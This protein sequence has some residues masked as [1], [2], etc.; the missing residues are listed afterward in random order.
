MVHAIRE[1]FEKH[2]KNPRREQ[3]VFAY[4]PLHIAT[5]A[6]LVEMMRMDGEVTAEE[7]YRVAQVLETKFGLPPE[8][9][10]E[11]LQLAEEQAEGATDYYQFT[12]LIKNHLDA[13]EK[14]RLIEY[15]WIVAYA[16]GE[17]H[18]YEEHLVRKIADLLYVS[19]DSF[20]AAKLRARKAQ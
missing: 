16:D 17:L 10:A 18:R 3:H 6:L 2:I 15:L 12:A 5:A 1:F 14:E 7:R 8:R 20:I 4:D 13:E 11:L 19:H 9:I